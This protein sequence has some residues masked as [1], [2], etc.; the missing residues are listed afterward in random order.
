MNGEFPLLE[1]G[2][3]KNYDLDIKEMA[4]N[5]LDFWNSEYGENKNLEDF[6]LGWISFDWEMVG[7]FYTDVELKDISLEGIPMA[8]EVVCYDPD[9]TRAE[10]GRYTQSTTTIAGMDY[11]DYCY[12]PDGDG[13]TIDLIE[14]SCTDD[15]LLDILHLDCNYACEVGEGRCIDVQGCDDPDANNLEG[16]IYTQSTTTVGTETDNP[17]E[18][19]DHCD[20]NNPNVLVEGIC[21]GFGFDWIECEH[22]CLDGNCIRNFATETEVIGIV[23]QPDI[24]T[25]S[26]DSPLQCD[27]RKIN[28]N[29]I[30][31]TIRNTGITSFTINQVK[32]Y[33]IGSTGSQGGDC[34]VLSGLNIALS[35]DEETDIIVPCEILE[36]YIGLPVEMDLQIIGRTPIKRHQTVDGSI[37]GI[38]G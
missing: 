30:V 16:G 25:C 12:D 11:E 21:G 20:V 7:A 37:Y 19:E 2:V 38:V 33:F 10:D 3:W 1:E 24:E 32:Q 23:E 17:T 13:D 14:Y 29:N 15:G 31:M 9:H 18:I 28:S 27:Y 34:P 35:P 26:F 22:G 6:E 4:N 36:N 5:A 8:G